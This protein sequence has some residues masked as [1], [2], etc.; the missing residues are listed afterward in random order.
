METDNRKDAAKHIQALKQLV[1]IATR[2]ESQTREG[3]GNKDTKRWTELP[4]IKIELWNK[5]P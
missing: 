3:P 2:T 4:R 1:Y 5:I